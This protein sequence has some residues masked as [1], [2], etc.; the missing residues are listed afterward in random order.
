MRPLDAL[1]AALIAL[2][3]F[4][5]VV[6]GYLVVLD[7]RHP[8][9]PTLH[10]RAFNQVNLAA[11]ATIAGLFGLAEL[12]LIRIDSNAFTVLLALLLL[13]ISVP[14]IRWFLIYIRD[15]FE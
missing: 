1:A 14:S 13:G 11:C 2:V 4:N 9:I 12:R 10:D 15:G 3:P 6:A 7:R 8:G 5:W